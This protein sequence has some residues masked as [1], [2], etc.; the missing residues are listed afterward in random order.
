MVKKTLLCI[1]ICISVCIGGT[2]MS[3]AKKIVFDCD[4]STVL[5]IF[6]DNT[7]YFITTDIHSIE[8]Y[9]ANTDKNLSLQDFKKIP[10]WG[11]SVGV[12]GNDIISGG[13]IFDDDDKE[14]K[15]HMGIFRQTGNRVDFVEIYKKENGRIPTVSKAFDTGIIICYKKEFESVQRVAL[16]KPY[17]NKLIES[18][19]VIASEWWIRERRGVIPLPSGDFFLVGNVIGAKQPAFFRFDGDCVLQDTKTLDEILPGTPLVQG[20]AGRMLTGDSVLFWGEVEFF[21]NVEST[22][23]W[24]AVYDLQQKRI[25]KTAVV[26]PGLG[27]MP[28]SIYDIAVLGDGRLC[29]CTSSVLF[30]LNADFALEGYW[31]ADQKEP[32]GFEAVLTTADGDLLVLGS[33][34]FQRGGKASVWLVSPQ[35]FKQ[36][37]KSYSPSSAER[38]SGVI[39][40]LRDYVRLGD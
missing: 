33:T 26:T 12:Y 27:I 13:I 6:K 20:L 18:K 3:F 31:T 9:V 24:F 4:G 8:S 28:Y 17:E 38:E 11:L 22:R 37:F 25:T 39:E 29:L 30:M 32:A 19:D 23:W 7:Y 10:F 5:S 2:G 34:L 40:D 14:Y 36:D 16:Y 15:T 35:D 1:L 21:P